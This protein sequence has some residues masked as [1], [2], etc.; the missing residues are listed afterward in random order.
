MKALSMEVKWLG[1]D[2]DHSYQY[3][4]LRGC[5]LSPSPPQYAIYNNKAKECTKLFLRYL[6][7]NYTTV[8][9]LICFDLQG[10]I[11]GEPNQSN[12]T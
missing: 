8:N 12:T 5:R 11:N 2:N 1:N 10:K 3:N 7:N 9:I 6:N 4:A